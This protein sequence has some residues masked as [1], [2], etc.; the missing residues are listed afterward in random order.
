MYILADTVD[1]EP[2]FRAY[3]RETVNRHRQFKMAPELWGAFFTVYVNFLETRGEL[4]DDQKAAWKQ[5]GEIFDQE[6]Q[7]HLRTLGLPHV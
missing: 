6:C 3:A 5:M 1:D 4:T 2:A 7:S